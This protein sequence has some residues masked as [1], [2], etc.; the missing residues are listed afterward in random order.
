MRWEKVAVPFKVDVDTPAITERSLRNQLRHRAQFEWSPWME[1]ANYLLANHLELPTRRSRTR[2]PPF[3]NEDRFENEITK[4]RALT[5]L[6]RP[7]EAL[8]ARD[9][10]LALGTHRLARSR[11]L[12]AACRRTAARR[13]PSSSFRINIKKDPTSWIAHNNTARLAVAK[14]DFD[15]AIKEMT[16]AEAGA[17]DALKSA[18]ADLI[19]RLRQHEDINK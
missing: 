18:H 7:T 2:T 6:G 9:R 3:Q 15:T 16:L 17:P 14:G 13:K 4:S 11:C 19:R 12:P 1:A 10:A 8:A 5:V